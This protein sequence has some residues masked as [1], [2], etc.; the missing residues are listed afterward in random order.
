[1]EVCHNASDKKI[2]PVTS[3]CSGGELL[4][5]GVSHTLM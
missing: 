5:K 3:I 1:M 4:N 2:I